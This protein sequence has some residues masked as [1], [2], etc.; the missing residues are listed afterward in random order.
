MED[1]TKQEVCLRSPLMCVCVHVHDDV[2]LPIIS[3]FISGQYQ[4][5]EENFDCGQAGQASKGRQGSPKVHCRSFG[6]R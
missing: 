3:L 4:S 1:L 6:L 5:A 2:L